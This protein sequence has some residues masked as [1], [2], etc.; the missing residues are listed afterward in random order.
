MKLLDSIDARCKAATAGPWRETTTEKMT[1][2]E[3][4]SA[5]AKHLSHG[6][7]ET[8]SGVWAVDHQDNVPGDDPDRP[9]HAVLACITGNGPDS[10]VNAE[11]IAH[12]RTDLPRLVELLRR[13]VPLLEL[14]A[15]LEPFATGYHPEEARSILRDLDTP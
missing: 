7:R 10:P 9:E 15:S 12:A 4:A 11:L 13:A 8:V 1:A 2:D 14:V 3:Q 6:Y 5:V